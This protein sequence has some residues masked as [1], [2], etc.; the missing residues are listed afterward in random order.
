MVPDHP[1]RLASLAPQDDGDKET[2]EEP[3]SDIHESMPSNTAA[4]SAPRPRTTS[5][6]IRMTPTSRST[7]SSG[8][9]SGRPAPSSS[10]PASTRRWPRNAAA[11]SPS[12]SPKDSGH[13]HRA[14]R[15][16]ERHHLAS[17]L[18][19]LRQLRPFPERAFPRAGPRDGLRHRPLMSHAHLRIPFEDEDVV[20]MVRKVFA[21][22]V[23]FHDGDGRSRP[24]S[25]CTG[26]AATRRACNAS[27]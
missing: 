23:T 10:T 7:T 11:R 14:G 12:R 5:A 8:R 4:M 26:S 21:G 9:S 1:S 6:A 15:G 13:R 16:R 3:V 25:W 27:A 2:R 24:G 17:A 22:R 19:P 20:A 18:R